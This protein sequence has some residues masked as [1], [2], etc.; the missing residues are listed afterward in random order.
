MSLANV[1][2]LRRVPFTQLCL[3]IFLCD[4]FYL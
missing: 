2:T 1:R 3:V 4:F